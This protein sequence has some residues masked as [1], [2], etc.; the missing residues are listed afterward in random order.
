MCDNEGAKAPKPKKL[1]KKE[2]R[3]ILKMKYGG[4]CAYCGEELGDRW[5]ADHIKPVLR[6]S[7]V[8]YDENGRIARNDDGSWKYKVVGMHKPEHDILDNMNPACVQCNLYKSC[9]GLESWRKCIRENFQKYI[10]RNMGLRAAKRFGLLSIHDQPVEFY[11]EKYD[12]E[13]QEK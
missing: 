3:Q 2:Q 5:H 1:S 13:H 6:R 11:F 9:M 12:R 7:K 8:V 10:Q 4:R